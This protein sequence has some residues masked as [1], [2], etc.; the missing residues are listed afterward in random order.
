MIYKLI[1][2]LVGPVVG[3]IYKKVSA[4]R[5]EGLKPDYDKYRPPQIE[6]HINNNNINNNNNIK[7]KVKENK[8][9]KKKSISDIK[10]I[11]R[12]DSDEFLYF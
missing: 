2:L 1:S 3:Y 8:I 10:V 12:E 4:K 7:V 5:K 9:V 6:N 11:E